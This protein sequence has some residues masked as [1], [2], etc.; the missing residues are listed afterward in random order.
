MLYLYAYDPAFRAK[1]APKKFLVVSA[2][3]GDEH[4]E[5]DDYC[6]YV[7][8]F[9][10]EQGIPFVH[11]TP[12]LGFHS[13]SWQSLRGFYNLKHTV[14]SKAFP[15]TCTDRLKIQVIYKYLEHWIGQNYGVPVGQ[16]H[17]FYRFM[18]KH[19]RVRVMV[20]IAKG[21]EKRVADPAKDPQRWKRDCIETVY[22]LI[23]LGLDRAGCQQYIR[24][25]GH[26]VP[27]P[28]NCILC[29]FMSEVE[30]VWLYRFR[31]AD[32]D[33]WVRIE[34]NKLIK[35]E[36]MGDRN[37]GVWGKKLLPEVLEGAIAKFGHMTDEELQEYKFSHGHC[38][39]SKY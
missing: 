5:S 16:K 37:L 3:T 21:E 23:D 22:P 14:G 35:N 24:S 38:V 12:D 36:H 39:A 28:S 8:E 33:D 25:T 32:F 30:L 10:R 9:C 13:E 2:D 34:R 18:A 19:G 15:K 20:G 4:P 27:W 1:Y 17:G 6:D 11:I 29:P 31:R 26:P 7:T